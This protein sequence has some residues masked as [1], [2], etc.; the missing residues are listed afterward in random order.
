MPIDT[1]H[2]E[3]IK[4]KKRWKRMDAALDDQDAVHEAGEEY[5][6]KTG[7]MRQRELSDTTGES[8]KDYENYKARARFPEITSQALT[9]VVGLVFEKTPLGVSDEEIT[10]SKQTNIEL[11]RESVR[12]VS[13]KGRD[14]YVIDAPTAEEG[15][16]EPYI[17]TYP[18]ECLINW[19]L[20]DRRS[21]PTL[22]VLREEVRKDDI[23][24]YEHE[25]ET[26]YRRYQRLENGSIEMARIKRADGSDMPIE[27]PIILPIQE[28][29]VVVPGSIDLKYNCDPIPLAPVAR[30]AFSYYMKSALYELALYLTGQPTPVLSGVT[31]DEY[32]RIIQ[33]GIGS[34][35]VWHIGEEAK[36][37]FLEVSGNG[38]DKILEGMQDQLKQAETYAVRLTQDTGG[39]E[40]A[41]AIALRA[42]TQ[43]A[44][45][46]GIADTVSLAVTR[47][48]NIRAQW[49][50]ISAPEPF[51]IK[52]EFS[53]GYASEQIINALNTAVNSG[54]IPRAILFDALRQAGF[55]EMTD[56]EIETAIENDVPMVGAATALAS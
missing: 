21:E 9:G 39:V 8:H 40:A 47:A 17:A 5:L 4:F 22:A 3:Y 12:A 35:A 50:G 34:S 56:D 25:T 1:E 23:D 36:A 31:Q 43:H 29:P 53:T 27:D 6:P 52:T 26:V 10:N 16:G 37:A 11:A 45:V 20:S 44:S 15:G 55:T 42:A 30:C 13:S 46:Y 33:Q 51:Q 24:I 38:I 2:P 48:Q 19:Q 54:N 32:D 28:W 49:A 7:G 41:A 18:A 14:V